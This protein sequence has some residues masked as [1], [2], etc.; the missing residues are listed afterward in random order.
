VSAVGNSKRVLMWTESGF[1]A[2]RGGI[3]ASGWET[4]PGEFR[5]E[6]GPRVPENGK[7]A[8]Q[9]EFGLM[10]RPIGDSVAGGGKVPRHRD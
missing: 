6:K 10:E 7:D 5:R 2:Y 9:S 4:C 1:E 3:L 8:R